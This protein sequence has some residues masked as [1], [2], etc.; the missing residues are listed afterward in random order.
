MTNNPYEILGVREGA[1]MDEIK[2]AYRRKAKEYHPDLHPEDPCANEKMQ[3]INEAYEALS[4]PGKYQSQRQARPAADAYGGARRS[5]Q[6][7]SW[8]YAYYSSAD[9][10]D[11]WN[12]WQNTWN[13]EGES[14]QARPTGA[15]LN[16]FRGVLRV[17]G[18]ILLFR[19]IMTLL[20]IGLFGFFF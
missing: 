15:I 17:I 16:P 2:R 18:G 1:G 13:G 8:Q 6:A 14:R 20:R 4:N 3:R 12:G 10:Q 5:N 7:G 9:G 11:F 19:F